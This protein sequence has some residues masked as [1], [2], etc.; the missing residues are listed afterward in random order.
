[1]S[2]GPSARAEAIEARS[3]IPPLRWCGYRRARRCGVRRRLRAGLVVVHCPGARDVVSDGSERV[4]RLERVLGDVTD[5][6]PADGAPG[7]WAH[8]DKVDVVPTWWPLV[9]AGPEHDRAVGT[10]A[11]REQAE[12]RVHDGGLAASGFADQR[13]GFPRVRASLSAGRSLLSA[14]AQNA[15]R[16]PPLAQVVIRLSEKF[17]TRKSPGRCGR[18]LACQ[19]RGPSVL[20]CGR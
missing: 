2:S 20:R 1:M 4:E 9:I 7:A 10:G 16:W 18:R 13:H 17:P 8:V 15:G 12:D 3:S 14:Q 6:S 5:S 11:R 19:R